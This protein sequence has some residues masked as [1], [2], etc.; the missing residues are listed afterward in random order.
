[1]HRIAK[2]VITLVS[3][4]AAVH[5]FPQ[6]QSAKDIAAAIRLTE[7]NYYNSDAPD[8]IP[9]DNPSDMD[10]QREEFEGYG[11]KIQSVYDG[12]HKKSREVFSVSKLD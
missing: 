11:S 4:S 1:M 12:L 6:P 8:L 10:N 9:F 5:C 3:I 2:I 7:Q